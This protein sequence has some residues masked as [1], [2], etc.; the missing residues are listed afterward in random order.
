MWTPRLRWI[1][2]HRMHR[3]IPKFH[4]AHLGPRRVT[5]HERGLLKTT[6]VRGGCYPWSFL[7]YLSSRNPHNICY[8]RLSAFG[9]AAPDICPVFVSV[10]LCRLSMT[11]FAQFTVTLWT[12]NG[13]QFDGRTDYDTTTL[14]RVKKKTHAY[15]TTTITIRQFLASS[16]KRIRRSPFGQSRPTTF[17]QIYSSFCCY[18]CYCC[19]CGGAIELHNQADQPEGTYLRSSAT[20]ARANTA[21][22]TTTSVAISVITRRTRTLSTR[23]QQL[24][25]SK[26]TRQLF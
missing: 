26:F 8:R 13:F 4:E 15:I 10:C 22:N 11:L 19:R 16:F 20:I 18:C 2:A 12:Q 14:Q 25:F 21:G 1:P 24:F 9:S 5:E 23:Y 17:Y 3:N 6:A 7:A